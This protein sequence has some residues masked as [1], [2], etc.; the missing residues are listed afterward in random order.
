MKMKEPGPNQWRLSWRLGVYSTLIFVVLVLTAVMRLI[1][2][3]ASTK[4]IH[5]QTLHKPKHVK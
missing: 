3:D 5:V 1:A 4:S 2:Q